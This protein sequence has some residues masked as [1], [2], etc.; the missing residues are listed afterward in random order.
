MI[1]REN[2]K[3]TAIH[4]GHFK[5]KL[6]EPY[7]LS[8][9]TITHIDC[10]WVLIEDEKG[11]IGIGEVVPLPG[12]GVECLED[13]MG[14]FR[15]LHD[16]QQTS[17]LRQKCEELKDR[18]PFSASAVM[19]ALEFPEYCEKVDSLVPFPLMMP[20]SSGDENVGMVEKFAFGLNCGYK[21]FKM[22]I[23][24]DV[25]ED[26][27]SVKF[28]LDTFSIED[29]KI[30]FDANQGYS[31]DEAVRFSKFLD[32]LQSSKVLWV[33]QPLAVSRHNEMALL[34]KNTKTHFIL[35][36]SIYDEKDLIEAKSIGCYGVKLKLYKHFGIERTCRLAR[37]AAELGLAVVIGNGV[38]TD[39][40][41]LQEAMIFSLYPDLFTGGAECNGFLKIS[42]PVIFA[43]L[44]LDN[45]ARLFWQGN[46]D[47]WGEQIT[48]ELRAFA[49]RIGSG[50]L[51]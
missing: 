3:I 34:T 9:A 33:E 26:I 12:Y 8:F 15:D 1:M 36:E 45:N 44:S 2:K 19:S 38:S 35:D 49:Q 4:S 6:K 30:S 17:E 23:G 39:I 27:R 14:I 25:R 46:Q 47:H 10:M 11:K 37:K 7:V 28:L 29:Y 41:N 16:I 42:K 32:D 22:K 40:G 21:N 43:Q 31:W 5:K 18:Y 48:K 24:K 13:V 50:C 51:I 20:L